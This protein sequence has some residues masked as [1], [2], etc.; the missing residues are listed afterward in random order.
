MSLKVALSHHLCARIQSCR[1]D[2]RSALNSEREAYQ[3]YKLQLGDEHERTRESAQVLKHLTEQAVVLQRRINDVVKGQLLVIPSLTIQQP[4]FQNVLEMLNVVNGIL[5]IQIR[6]K[7]LEILRDE[8]AKQSIGNQQT[9]V[10]SMT[11]SE[12]VDQAAALLNNE[13]D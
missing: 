9:S 10:S 13:I 11:I 3:I 4:S 7:D 1:G 8:F 6:E 2:F 5:F 12:A